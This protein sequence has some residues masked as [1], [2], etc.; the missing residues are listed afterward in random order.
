MRSVNEFK[1]FVCEIS[2]LMDETD[3]DVFG[4]EGIKDWNGDE[5]DAKTFIKYAIDCGRHYT[6]SEFQRVV[7]ANEENFFNSYIFI[8]NNY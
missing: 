1:V 3:L 7:N 2:D 6:L 5:D 8:T 4:Q